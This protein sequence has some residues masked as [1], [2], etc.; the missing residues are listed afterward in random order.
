MS[1]ENVELVRAENTSFRRLADR[2]EIRSHVLRYFDPDCEYRPVEEINPLR[3]HD[4]LIEWIEGWL[5]AWIRFSIEVDEVVDGGAFVFAVLNTNGLG[6]AS[7][8][9]IRQRFFHVYEIRDGRILR[10]REYLD[11]DSALAAAGLLG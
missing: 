10:M 2:G 7:G 4:A 6:R 9:E 8:V 11:R 3:G 5:E 1:R